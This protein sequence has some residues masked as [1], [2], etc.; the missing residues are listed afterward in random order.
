M[1]TLDFARALL[2]PSISFEEPL[3]PFIQEKVSGLDLRNDSWV[4][5]P[6]KFDLD[7]VEKRW[8]PHEFTPRSPELAA[9]AQRNTPESRRALAE[10]YI[11]EATEAL[12]D[13]IATNKYENNRLVQAVGTAIR[14]E[15]ARLTEFVDAGCPEKA[16]APVTPTVLPPVSNDFLRADVAKLTYAARTLG[17]WPDATPAQLLPRILDRCGFTV[18]TTP[19]ESDFEVVN[20]VVHIRA[21]LSLRKSTVALARALARIRLH[22]YQVETILPWHCEAE[23]RW[24]ALFLL[25]DVE[26]WTAKQLRLFPVTKRLIKL[27]LNLGGTHETQPQDQPR[28]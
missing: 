1:S 3:P 18:E 4:L 12:R 5:Y 28:W 27:R 7:C 15:L 13:F 17:G 26:G 21:G 14:E 11:D 10:H 25:P 9:L 8:G 16:E 6:L 2:D 22:H 24:A 23:W 19:L 20:R